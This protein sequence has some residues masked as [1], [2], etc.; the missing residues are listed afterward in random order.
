MTIVTR[1]RFALIVGASIWTIEMGL[2][3]A[4]QWGPCGSRENKWGQKKGG[5]FSFTRQGGLS[6]LFIRGPGGRSPL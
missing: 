6:P 1:S 4:G 3:F 5:H 2:V